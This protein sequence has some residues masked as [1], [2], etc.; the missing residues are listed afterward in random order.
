MRPLTV[1]D[2]MA[3]EEVLFDYGKEYWKEGET[4]TSPSQ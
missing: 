4:E 1:R 3:G 2:I